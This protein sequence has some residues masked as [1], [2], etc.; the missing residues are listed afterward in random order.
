MLS[1]ART[2][3]QRLAGLSFTLH[4]ME[5]E[6]LPIAESSWEGQS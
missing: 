2:Y 6:L 4:T 3:N 1:P 5:P